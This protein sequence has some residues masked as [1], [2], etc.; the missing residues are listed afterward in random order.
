M[1]NPRKTLSP[2]YLLVVAAFILTSNAV[3]ESID[4]EAVEKINWASQDTGHIVRSQAFLSPEN[5]ALLLADKLRKG[6]PIRASAEDERHYFVLAA[7]LMRANT[8]FNI[9]KVSIDRFR[10]LLV[11]KTYC[12]LSPAPQSEESVEVTLADPAPKSSS[13]PSQTAKQNSAATE[14]AWAELVRRAATELAAEER[15]QAAEKI[16]QKLLVEAEQ[17]PPDAARIEP[18][19]PTIR[20]EMVEGAE[21]KTK[22]RKESETTGTAAVNPAFFI[23]LGKLEPGD[24]IV[25]LEMDV[26]NAAPPVARQPRLFRFVVHDYRAKKPTQ[27]REDF[28]NTPGLAP[29]A[30]PRVPSVM[31]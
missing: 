6:D 23:S 5:N 28:T 10:R 22:E 11:V 18:A 16:A 4:L 15:S 2:K 29:L 1:K 9:R 30:D 25:R 20:R 13:P 7:G 24:W 14:S 8:L 3:A 31:P 21:N 27:R 26:E 19:P 12:L 17:L